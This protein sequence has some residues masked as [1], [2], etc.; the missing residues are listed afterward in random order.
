MRRQNLLPSHFCL[1]AVLFLHLP[2]YIT[3]PWFT[4][5]GPTEVVIVQ[6]MVAG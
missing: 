6:V 1:P 4:L 2:T 5:D 3:N